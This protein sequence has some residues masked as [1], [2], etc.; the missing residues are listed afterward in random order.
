MEVR[1]ESDLWPRYKDILAVVEAAL[2]T[3]Q[4][5]IR[6]R[7]EQ[8]LKNST[9][10]FQKL[11]KT[12]PP[13]P[14]D[15]ELLKK[16]TTEG[17]ELPGS[18]GKTQLSQLLVDEAT[19]ISDL[20]NLNQVAAVQLLLHGE[21]QLPQH[22]G[23]TRGL[24]AVT[25]FYD[26]KKSI[27]QALRTLLSSC[28]GLTWSSDVPEE[29]NSFLTTYTTQL[30]QAGMVESI[31]SLLSTLD[32]TK[33]L[34]ELQKKS[35]LG[36]AQHV[37]TLCQLHNDT[38]QGLADC[39]YSYAAQSGMQA[40]ETIKV[41]DYL[42]GVTAGTS[43]GAL[44][45]V[46][47]TLTMAVLQAIDGSN[48]ENEDVDAPIIHDQNFI[49]NISRE[50]DGKGKKWELPG[51][52]SILQFAWSTS[53]AALR[54]GGVVTIDNCPQLEEDETFMD[55][56]L[57]A[58][59]FHAIP[60][61]IYESKA[62][63]KEE[64]Y[65]RRFHALITDFLTLM[66]LKIKELRN[67]ADDAARNK[68]MHE[69]EGLQYTVHQT[70]QH[71]QQL[72]LAVSGL[73][74]NDPLDL[75]LAEAY[76]T[77][78]DSGLVGL[79]SGH[80]PAKQ[81][82]L[83]KFVRLAGDLLMPS[84]YVPYVQMLSGLADSPG[85]SVHCFNLL[86]LN[87]NGSSN[88]SLDHFFSSLNQYYLNLRMDPVPHGG[89]EHTIY[90]TKPLTRGISPQEMEGL[91]AVLGLLTTLARRSDV[92][93]VCMVEHPGW[94]VLPTLVGLLSCSVP[95]NIKAKLMTLLAGVAK[96]ADNVHTIWQHVEAQQLLGGVG[97]KPGITEELE[98]IEARAE[99]YPL[100]KA[101]IKVL[102]TLTDVEI[103]GNLGAGTR[104][105][106]LLPYMNYLVDSVF[107][108]FS[109]RTYKNAAERWEVASLLLNMFHKLLAEYEPSPTDFQGP[110]TTMGLHPGF[111]LLMHVHQSSLL[112]RTILFVVD[113]CRAMLDTFSPFA[114]KEHVESA[115][116]GA[117]KL[118]SLSL[119]LSEDFIS[120]GRS[121]AASEVLTSTSKLLL[122]IN[123]RSGK[124]D[125][126]LNI[127]R[128]V[129]Y[130]HW[131]P[132]AR[133]CAVKILT[134]VASSPSNQ[135]DLLATFT[136]SKAIS[137]SV[138]KAFT[139][140][141]DSAEEEE[142]ANTTSPISVK[143][144]EPLASRLAIVELIQIGINMSA[145]TLGH[146]LL[147]FDIMNVSQSQLQNPNIAGIRTPFHSILGLLTP[148][149]P[150]VPSALL[151]R[152]PAL[153][154]ALYTLINSLVS[155]AET[156]E[157]VLRFLRS[158]CD[159]LCSQLACITNILEREDIDSQRTVACMLR[160][161]AVEMR[162]LMKSRQKSQL[163]K[164]L[165]LLL[166]SSGTDD[167]TNSGGETSRLYNDTTFSQLSRSTLQNS[168]KQMISTPLSNHRL[169]TVLNMINFEIED[170]SSP[171]WDLFDDDQVSALLQ[172]C[173]VENAAST[174][175]EK[176]IQVPK[177]HKFL[178]QELA[179]LQGTTAMHQRA[180]IQSEIQSILL[181]AVRWNSVQEGAAARRQLLDAW[182]QVTEVLLLVAPDDYV[183]PVGKQQILLQLLQ[184]LL[185]K[186]S[187]DNVVVGLSSLVSSAV[188]LLL[189]SLRDTYEASPEKKSVLGE[190][191]VGV[192]DAT[193]SRST[194][195]DVF[196]SS[197]QVILKGLVG[198]INNNGSGSQLIRTNLYASLVAYLRIGKTSKAGSEHS[199]ELSEKGK[200]Q[201]VNMEVIQGA[202]TNLLDILA[203]DACSGHEVR[204]MLAFSV[205]EEI[206]LMDRQC[207]CTRFLS[208]RGFIKH[209]IES[210]LKD[211]TGLINLLTKADGNIR[212]LYVYESKIG[213]LSR[214]ATSPLGA[215][216]LLQAGL[217]NRLSEL[218]IIDL[219][220][221][222]DAILM[223]NEA[224]L[225]YGVLTLYQAVLF[226]VL[227][228]LQSIL[229]TLG[230]S[231]RCAGE[232]VI[233]F[234]AAHD[235]VF[236]QILRGSTARS[237]LNDSL[238]Q[239]LALVTAVVSR[240]GSIDLR[241]DMVDPAGFEL[242]GLLSRMQKQM[243]NLLAQFQLSDSLLSA[244]Q[245]DS[246]QAD[247]STDK[248]SSTDSALLTILKI[249]SNVT[250]Y[251]RSVVS[252]SANSSKFCKLVVSPSLM[253]ATEQIGGNISSKSASLGLFVA[254]INNVASHLSKSQVTLNELKD[255]EKNISSFSTQELVNLAATNP[256]EKLPGPVLRKIAAS[257]LASCISEK[258]LEVTLSAETVEALSFLLWRHLEHY[259]L[260]STSA[261]VSS[262]TDSPY[263]A[264]LKSLNEGKDKHFGIN[265]SSPRSSFSQFDIERFKSEVRSTLNDNF[266]DKLDDILEVVETRTKSGTSSAGFLQAIIRRTKRLSQ[267]YT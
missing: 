45:D 134:Y 65:I 62:F 227:R 39:I 24:V 238:L 140:A 163:C 79:D 90:R 148:Q 137:N 85:S 210:L 80:T 151:Y 72:L 203:R 232:Q 242:T 19:I 73:Y 135:S 243:V 86:K 145:P 54:V 87:A 146:F 114:G 165:S 219:R 21:D 196:S 234:V 3:K 2:I 59:V 152:Q 170:V 27:V 5:G 184:A 58:N 240:A 177:L 7:F 202:G 48:G 63:T 221:D 257:K 97:G 260:Y 244:L 13:T 185:N 252:T 18:E 130:G 258:E 53:L 76:W 208:E 115:A 142:L 218:S 139:E 92:A 44:D 261:A 223:R 158:S 91:T 26:A 43:S 64:F 96:S 109:T 17:I 176:L 143:R 182:R 179:S 20:F 78:A 81:I 84:L 229:S 175:H 57:S 133:Y 205:L 209:I 52:L 93:R 236:S 56:A 94:S 190:T 173:Q 191:Y 237:S 100:T 217:I 265:F 199:L 211:E 263:Q 6:L 117:L 224:D 216:L 215:E 166:D 102:D 192:L 128:F 95:T 10:V 198:W 225:V 267:L 213:L 154:T 248:T 193:M 123:A 212:D 74:V 121:A 161:T 46:T 68:M 251:A 37:S 14:E 125:H 181:Y 153:A 98:E 106:G 83:Y 168:T 214:V 110:S 126:M 172:Q 50:L 162:V 150:G 41:L 231:N 254:S 35:A 9:S 127:A 38:R 262:S 22:P 235:D 88:V 119:K 169:A 118:L 49:Q 230:S 116:T 246:Q 42:A 55:L 99:E 32:W 129:L 195:K 61:L 131:M 194:S 89:P 249:I 67:R 174:L 247:Q 138:L 47:L 157:P 122:G 28:T 250:S 103:P 266:F 111:Y 233:R 228:L 33:D 207:Y 36:D 186:V 23:L 4:T 71:F 141:L 204:R 12:P 8:T 178:S 239:E 189:T 180:Q 171:N 15:A 120:C 241:P 108:K 200:L 183:S 188:L 112:L 255:R 101:F 259:L 264:T 30:I 34:A 160:A 70:G 77:A 155:N 113:E 167:E 69:Q 75:G 164:I 29:L 82:A 245:N 104:L 206:V 66:P 136:A 156:Y 149:E 31:L 159:F 132:E 16:A 147:G 197:L 51:L 1:C 105:P 107:L 25:L 124:P 187:S 11:L 256:A 60:N 40:R 201:R 220:P 226:P 222:V 253:E 144:N